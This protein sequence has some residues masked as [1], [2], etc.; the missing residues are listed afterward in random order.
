MLEVRAVCARMSLHRFDL[1]PTYS[2][3]VM[4]ASLTVF[5]VLFLQNFGEK[6]T[7]SAEWKDNLGTMR[8]PAIKVARG[9]HGIGRVGRD[10]IETVS[11]WF[12]VDRLNNHLDF[13]VMS[14]FGDC[15]RPAFTETK[16]KCE[17][18]HWRK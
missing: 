11:R 1:N 16:F 2:H 10:L 9:M 12:A 15:A 14:F 5:I 18:G 3:M 6:K 4:S 13:P 17:F 8:R 7:V